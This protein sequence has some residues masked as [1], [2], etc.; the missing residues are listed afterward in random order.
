MYVPNAK[1]FAVG[2]KKT[3]VSRPVSISGGRVLERL[4]AAAT[5]ANATDFCGEPMT[6]NLP[7]ASMTSD[8]LVSNW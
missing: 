2:S 8:A 7:S 1:T 3:V 6:G 5:S 4:A